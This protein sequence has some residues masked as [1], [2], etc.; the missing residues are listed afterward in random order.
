[1]L[2]DMIKKLFL[3]DQ[4][5]QILVV[6]DDTHVRELIALHVDSMGFR[7]T[8]MPDGAQALNAIEKNK[9]RFCLFLLDIKMPGLSGVQ[10]ARKIRKHP[11]Y[12]H[13]PILFLTGVFSPSELK[14]ITDEIPESEAMRKP[15]TQSQLRAAI[16][17]MITPEHA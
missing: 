17:T 5:Q 16:N 12:A 4:R 1:M 15:F 2:L 11:G 13:T 8:I 7:V 10:L 3:K 6:E 14:K 9:E